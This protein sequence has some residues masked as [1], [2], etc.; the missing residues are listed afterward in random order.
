MNENPPM[1]E[2]VHEVNLFY[3]YINMS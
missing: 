1:Y 3:M 2:T